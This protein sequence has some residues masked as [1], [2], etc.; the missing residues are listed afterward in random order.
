M[1]L[2]PP[3]LDPNLRLFSENVLE[4]SVVVNDELEQ[5]SEDHGKLIEQK[6]GQC[7]TWNPLERLEYLDELQEIK[8]RWEVVYARSNNLGE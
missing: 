2:Q 8:E 3:P 7:A 4:D 5:L 1:P 6:G